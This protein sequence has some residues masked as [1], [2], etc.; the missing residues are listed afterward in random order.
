MG[1]I[2]LIRSAIASHSVVFYLLTLPVISLVIVN[3]IL[4]FTP[5]LGF[6]AL[7]YHLTLPKLWLLKHQWFYP[8]GLLYY[9]VMPRLAETLFIPLIWLMGTAGPKL[10]QFMAGIGT[11]IVI[12]KIQGYLKQSA[13]WKIISVSLFYCTWLVSWQSGSA[14][15][16]LIRTF[17]EVS[18]L[19]YLVKG[20]W[21]TGGIFLGLAIGTKWLSLGTLGI[22]SLVF[23]P[24]IIFPAL[25]VASP[26]FFLSYYY[27]GNPVYPIFSGLTE[28]SFASLGSALQHLILTPWYLTVP[29]DD[30]IS[31][32]VGFIF[33]FALI[34]IFKKN[35]VIK[36]IALIGVLGSFLT[37]VLVPPSSR[38]FLPYFPALIIA[39]VFYISSHKNLVL[40]N[41]CIWLTV[42]SSLFTLSLRL[43]AMKKYVPYL[44]GQEDK[45]AFLVSQARKLSGTFIDSD[46]FVANL[47][48][49]SKIV[50]D[51]LHNLFYFPRDFDHTSWVS[52]I[53][54]YDYLVTIGENSDTFDRELIHTNNLGIQVFKIIK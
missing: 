43:V 5:E 30:Y 16:D 26:W 3:F 42:V 1:K 17:L 49:N 4:V 9:S 50:V 52:S 22:F 35:I 25:L 7:W 45:N 31:L 40:K 14:Y 24:Q 36:R 10:L 28:N 18:A 46:G 27:T 15:I 23:G 13:L 19:F 39:S 51:K 54:P 6:D 11:G 41:M 29:F 48:K 32:M 2:K 47:P 12:W 21:K 34:S 37:M 53:T 20:S 8:G 38:Y 33:A 44:S